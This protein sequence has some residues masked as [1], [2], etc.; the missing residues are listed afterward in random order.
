ML[1]RL[2]GDGCLAADRLVV[3]LIFN[4]QL[5]STNCKIQIDRQFSRRHA[6]LHTST[7]F[8]C[9]PTCP[10]D[11]VVT[12]IFQIVT[13]KTSQNDRL[14]FHCRPSLVHH[15]D[16]RED[17]V[18][19]HTVLANPQYL[20]MSTHKGTSSVSVCIKTFGFEADVQV[21]HLDLCRSKG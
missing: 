9:T 7:T 13:L 2:P 18:R 8:Q 21:Q 3:F 6:Q 16:A 17:L 19:K 12:C 4:F 14:K 1:P 10:T 5:L 20:I 11:A 15:F